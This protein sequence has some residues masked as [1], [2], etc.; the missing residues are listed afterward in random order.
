LFFL[1][2]LTELVLSLIES[3][4]GRAFVDAGA[5]AQAVEVQEEL[6]SDVVVAYI[7]AATVVTSS[8]VGDVSMRVRVDVVSVVVTVVSVG[9]VVV[10]VS[11]VVVV[12]SI[13]SIVVIGFASWTAASGDVVVETVGS[14]II[15]TSSS[16]LSALPFPSVK[17]LLFRRVH[18]S[19][20]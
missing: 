5:G 17:L 7:G 9:V 15:H 4:A 19:C 3:A 1:T 13:M 2:L 20:A 16:S 12:V 10:V 18:S 8:F 14:T 6:S 11:S